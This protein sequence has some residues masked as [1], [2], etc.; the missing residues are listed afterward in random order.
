MFASSIDWF[1]T[2]R[3][4]TEYLSLVF[5]SGAYQGSRYHPLLRP[6]RICPTLLLI[7]FLA[8]ITTT[9]IYPIL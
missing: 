7:E 5:G 6:I 3:T 2:S 8:H 4:N 1:Y 9:Q